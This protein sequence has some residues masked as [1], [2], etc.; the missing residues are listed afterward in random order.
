M[1]TV[2]DALA[3]A[4]TAMAGIIFFKWLVLATPLSKI[5]GLAPAVATV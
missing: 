2:V 3:I 1:P 4:L 5:P